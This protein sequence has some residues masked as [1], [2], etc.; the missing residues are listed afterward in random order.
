MWRLDVYYLHRHGMLTPGH[1]SSLHWNR[2]GERVASIGMWAEAGRIV[3]KYRSRPRGAEEW[4]DMEYPVA[5][6]WTAC[7]FGGQRPWFLCPRCGRRVAVLYGGTIYACRHC[8]NLAYESQREAVHHR[9]LNRAHKL[10]DRLGGDGWWSKPKGMH[11]KTFDR[12]FAEYQYYEEAS[13]VAFCR[14][15]KKILGW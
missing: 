14:R 11:Q 8:H 4:Q 7:N 12:L 9:L 2:N 5:L 10:R 3:L 13:N 15:A 1:A 6:D